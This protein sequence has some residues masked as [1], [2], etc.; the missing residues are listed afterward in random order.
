MNAH[1][2]NESHSECILMSVLKTLF[3]CLF[4]SRKIGLLRV[5]GRKMKLQEIP[6]KT[7]RQFFIEDVV[8]ADH[9]DCFTPDTPH[10]T[11]KVED[12]CFAKV[13]EMLDEAERERLGCR[14]TPEKPLIRLR[15]RWIHCVHTS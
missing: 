14:L 11:K 4:I 10:V 9:Q 5:K 12:Y 7:V 6:L 8:L 13:T 3:V 15:V 2:L 1:T